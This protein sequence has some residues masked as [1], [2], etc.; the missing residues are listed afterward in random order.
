MI[1][2]P[3]LKKALPLLWLQAAFLFFMG[4]TGLF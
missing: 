3:Q 1:F 4:N 2:E